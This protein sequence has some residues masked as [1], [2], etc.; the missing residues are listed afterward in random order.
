MAAAGIAL[1]VDIITAWL[2]WTMSKGSLNVKAAFLHNLTDAGASI[3]VLIGGAAIYW[4]DW[5]WVDPVLT[6]IIAGY[7]LYMSFGMLKR[8]SG[9]L[10]EDTPPGLSLDEVKQ[11][12]EKTGGVVNA[13]HIHVW[14]L[15]EERI[16]LEAHIR[17][18]ICFER[19][20]NLKNRIQEQ[21]RAQFDIGHCTLE[22]E[23]TEPHCG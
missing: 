10:M 8:T 16:A 21:L 1:L 7:I 17:T 22:L 5:T 4:L 14:Q 9:I 3:A 12:I 11:A 20:S 2:L 19:H 13:Y 18:D 23:A 15:D 6:L